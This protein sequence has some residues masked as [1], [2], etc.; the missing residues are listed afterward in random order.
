MMTNTDIIDCCQLKSRDCQSVIGKLS[1]QSK[2]MLMLLA[3]SISSIL[4]I[5]FVGYD[6]GQQALNN[7]IFNQ[8]ISLRESKAYQIENY[9][10]DLRSEVQTISTMPSVVSAM[11]E[12][13]EAYEEI[14]QQTIQP[15]W[16]EK[17]KAYYEEEFLPRLAQNVRG[18]PLL[19]SYIPKNLASRYLQY[20]YIANNSNPVGQKEFLN[21]ASDGSKYSQI[22]QQIQPIFRNLIDKFNY[23]DLF[24]I[25]IETGNIVYSVEK[26]TDFATNLDRGPYARSSLGEVL[27]GVREGRDLGFVTVSDFEPY[28]ASYAIPAAFI[29]A[30]IFNNSELIGVLA[31]QISIDQINRVMTGNENWQRDGLGESGETYLIGDDLRMRSASR[32]LIEDAEGYFKAIENRVSPEDIDLIKK[33][34]TSIFYQNINTEVAQK[35]LTGESGVSISE[36]YRG[37]TTLNAYSP[38]EITG[39]DWAII[40]QIDRSEAFAPIAKFENQVLF[41]TII[42]VLIVTGIAAFFSHQF[43]RPI[44]KLMAGFKKVGAGQTDTKVIVKAKD[45]FRTMAHSF[46]EMVDNLHHQRQLVARREKENEKL[47]LSILP[48]PIANRLKDGEEEIADSFPNVTVLFADLS[49]F[50][51]LTDTLSADETVSFFNDLVIAFDEAAEVYGVEKVKTIGSGYMAVS[52]LSVPRIDH[53]KRVVDFALEMIRILRSFNRDRN[54]N[55]KI[56][57]GINSGEVVAGIVGKSKF[58]Y[59]LWGDTVNIAHRLQVRGAE[60]VVQVTEDVYNSLTDIYDFKPVPDIEIPGKGKIKTWSVSLN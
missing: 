41:S 29:A 3:V 52:G 40:A 26:E 48:E 18:T 30:P 8:L 21:N 53:S 50:T 2:L 49:G 7:S 33:L 28:R 46:N 10:K 45:E 58:I 39:L 60:D 55:L 44:R 12:F 11:N 47:L 17:L 56:R 27:Q 51:E 4:A 15:E 22:H 32:F 9:F 23:Y 43:V 34:N 1:I 54:M 37:V 5:A 31:L 19:F 14:E 42:I 35:A 6:S 38:L 25:D 13:K 16:N 59:D 20:Y 57:I 36:D 24:L